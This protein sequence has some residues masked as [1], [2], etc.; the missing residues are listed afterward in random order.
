MFLPGAKQLG[1]WAAFFNTIDFGALRPAPEL[2]VNQPGTDYPA[3]FVASDYIAAA[4]TEFDDTS[5][6][7][8]PKGG[9]V[10][11]QRK[12]LP[13]RS[14]GTW[15]NAVTGEKIPATFAYTKDNKTSELTAPGSG[16][17]FL[18]IEAKKN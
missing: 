3:N 5:L 8:L 6:F 9:N 14:K 7:Y 4:T 12:K 2:V 13:Q 17:W 16:D 10:A 18:L 11:I 15:V 1:A